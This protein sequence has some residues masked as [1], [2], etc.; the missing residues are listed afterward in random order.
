MIKSEKIFSSRDELE[1]LKEII[2]HEL[3]VRSEGDY[4]L[5]LQREDMQHIDFMSVAQLES[6]LAS[7][8]GAESVKYEDVEDLESGAVELRYELEEDVKGVLGTPVEVLRQRKL[9]RLRDIDLLRRYNDPELRDKMEFG[10]QCDALALSQYTVADIVNN[11]MTRNQFNADKVRCLNS[12]SEIVELEKL[13]VTEFVLP[14][15]VRGTVGILAGRG[16]IGKS[17]MTFYLASLIIAKYKNFNIKLDEKGWELEKGEEV[18][19]FSGEEKFKEAQSRWKRVLLNEVRKGNI[20]LAEADQMVSHLKIDDLTYESVEVLDCKDLTAT[21]H[22][23]Y[24]ENVIKHVRPRLVVIDTLSKIHGL[25][26]SNNIHMSKLLGLYQNLASKYDVAIVIVH[27]LS[28]AGAKDSEEGDGSGVRGADAIV[29]NSRWTAVMRE[30]SKNEA[31]KLNDAAGQTVVNTTFAGRKQFIKF[32]VPKANYGP[33]VE[34]VWFQRGKDGILEH[35]VDIKNAIAA[36]YGKTQVEKVDSKQLLA[37]IQA[38]NGGQAVNIN[39]SK[40]DDDG[41]EEL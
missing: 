4:E 16:A 29:S 5:D 12:I 38:K 2:E 13:D 31:E 30:M 39:N 7:L 41:G 10:E 37:C 24:T 22:Y 40:L 26:E 8:N 1:K 3:V 36:A 6:Y 25:E 15:L 17:F 32:E 35:D 20:T 23:E 11:R 28:K 9:Q 14:G 33:D 18:L 34:P 27:H 21:E 19:Y